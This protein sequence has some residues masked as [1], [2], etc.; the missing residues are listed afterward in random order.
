MHNCS[1][2]ANAENQALIDCG[3][4]GRFIDGSI[5]P[6]EARKRLTTSI[7][8]RNV[9]GSPN[10]D[11]RIT[12]FVPI[13][14]EIGGKTIEEEFHITHLG[15]QKIILGMPWLE[16]H[17][18]LIDWRRKTIAVPANPSRK[19]GAITR[20]ETDALTER[21]A[22]EMWIRG[23]QFVESDDWL[24]IL[25]IE[26]Q[27]D[28]DY[29]IRI[30]Q[31]ASQRFAQQNE[32]QKEKVKLP[33]EYKEFKRVFE[34]RELGQL[35]ERRPWDH[36]I[37]LKPDFKP[38]RKSSFEMSPVEQERTKKWLKEMK[39]KGY[40]RP[41]ASPMTS[42]LFWIE[43][44]AKSEY[45]PCQDYRY[46]NNG[47]IKDAY[48]LPLIS[49]LLLRLKEFK[50][51][52]KFDVRWGYNNVRIKEGD[53]W[54]AAFSTPFGSFEPTVMFF[55]LCNSPST[56]Q[57]MMNE[58]FWDYIMEGWVVIY[59]DDILICAEN[60]ETLRTRTRKI[61]KR[62][63]E[64]DLYLKLEKCLFDKEEVDFLG[65]V[66]RHNKI[67]MDK[68]KLKGIEDW[69]EPKTVKQV[70]S[71]LGFCNFYRKFIGHYAEISKPLTE[72][73]RK[74]EPFIWN[75]ERQQAF[76]TLKAKFM[77][78][79]VLHMPDPTK[80]FILQ[81]DASKIALGAVL[82]QYA[83]DGELHP[84][85]YLSHTLTPAEKNYQVY[86]RELLAVLT[87]LRTWRNILKGSP[88]AIILHMDHK[89]LGFY[90][91]HN[92]MTDR[93]MRWHTEHCGTKR[94][95]ISGLK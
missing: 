95:G 64:K 43:K 78:A 17:N 14:Y 29:W 61:L 56:F 21:D 30:K 8:V 55:G 84:C 36:G 18:P 76:D 51:F 91:E 73:T 41:T 19:I 31:S 38:F 42:P 58:Y 52:T 2:L 82:K 12:H 15:D 47:T 44:K 26:A 24:R 62:L 59:M 13:K 20:E 10:R 3:A 69:E 94:I 28:A 60:L 72:L 25:L 9:D 4:E 34:E 7:R 74:E 33:E 54:K 85:G 16:H 75:E 32:E 53:E 1:N 6:W 5:V 80:Q 27:D 50:Y 81:T 45:R 66:I 57:R 88:H 89:N 49:D 83:E 93:Q 67:K 48:N 65:M 79:P 35:P 87:G 40:I 90:K 39:D 23:A 86:D 37:E 22:A 11:G 46:L 63:K 77:E 68:T 70:R 92:K 71:F